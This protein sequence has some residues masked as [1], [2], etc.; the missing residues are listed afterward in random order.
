[1]HLRILS[2]LFLCSA[3]AALAATDPRVDLM[4]L[5][6]SVRLEAGRVPVTGAPRASFVH[7]E[8][9]RLDGAFARMAHRWDGQTGLGAGTPFPVEI[10]CAAASAE[11]PAP[12]EDE[13]YSLDVATGG[14]VL[15]APCE[16]GVLHGLETL[17]SLLH[18]DDQGW[19]LQPAHV[20]DRPRFAWRGLLIDV[21]RHWEPMPVIERNLDAMAA[22]KLNVLHLHLTD[23]QGFRV[24]SLTHPELQQKGSDG[25]YFTQAQ[26]RELIAYAAARGIRVVPEFDV[27][28]HCTSW[29]VSH[30]ELASLPGP[31]GIER[32]WGVMDPVLDPTQEATYALLSDFFGEMARLFP[33]PF[34]HIG[35][36]ENNGVQW[37]A[38]PR[39]QAFIRDHG[40]KDNAGLHT[41]F[42]TRLRDILAKNGKHLAGWDEILQPGLPTTSVIESWRGA[43]SLAAAATQGYE[44]ILANGYYIDLCQ[45]ASEHYAADPIPADST[46]TA[47]QRARVLGGEATMWGEWVSPDTIDSRI[48]PRTAAIAERL[49][50]PATVTDVDD[51]YRRLAVESLR[52]EEAG[53]THLR[54]RDALLRNLVRENLDLP[55]VPNV[56]TFLSLIEPVK[57]YTRGALQPWMTQRFPLILVADAIPP[58]SDTSREFSRAARAAIYAANGID[59]AAC[60]KLRVQVAGWEDVCADLRDHYNWGSSPM[61]GAEATN[62]RLTL[63]CTVAKQV[64]LHLEDGRALDEKQVGIALKV[65]DD[66]STPDANATLL[67][68]VPV[69]R[70]L[71]EA[72]ALQAD[73]PTLSAA[74]WE[75]R[76]RKAAQPPA[77][78]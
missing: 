16:R 69:V 48:W 18:K 45:P 2:A 42:N 27:P 53:S 14:A 51:M 60:G 9:A 23:D 10:R 35:G 4:P 70:E 49:W 61:R 47:E 46:L 37:N 38:N 39:I 28:G 22:V 63:L 68:E 12:G 50:S 21:S 67:P 31:Y 30:P 17:L 24:E 78:P 32:A 54:N 71:V 77:T 6:Q 66:A 36:D 57:G 19:F 55:F 13:S 52:L 76:V 62:Q 58:E 56:R 65:A 20:A 40:L 34:L 8:T 11:V 5:P 41:Y 75:A 64:L 59:R 33:D 1:M 44:G 72:A 29:V 26:L 25:N 43:E 7:V 3:C 73:R 15:T 74:D